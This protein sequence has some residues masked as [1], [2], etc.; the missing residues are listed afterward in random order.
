MEDL[1][2]RRGVDQVAAFG[3]ELHVVGSDR[4]LLERAI[5]PYRTRPG[6]AWSLGATSLEDVF[7]QLMSADQRAVQ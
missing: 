3:T 4:A 7:I 1:R 6:L 5:A 2:G